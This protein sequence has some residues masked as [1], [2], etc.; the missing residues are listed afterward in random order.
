MISAFISLFLLA[1]TS[2]PPVS[3]F[4]AIRARA[5]QAATAGDN[6][7][8][9]ELYQDELFAAENLGPGNFRLARALNDL[10]E[11]NLNSGH[12]EK[13]LSLFQRAMALCQAKLPLA[14]DPN[15]KLH[16]D[17]DRNWA[18]EGVRS[19]FGA[20]KIHAGLGFF[21]EAKDE[22]RDAKQFCLLLADSKHLAELEKYHAN[23]QK[24][25]IRTN[26][27]FDDAIMGN[28][29]PAFNNSAARRMLRKRR[30]QL[31]SQ[32]IDAKHM[33]EKEWLSQLDQA[34]REFGG[35]KD[36][37]YRTTFGCI[38]AGYLVYGMYDKAQQ[39]LE[40]DLKNYAALET[41]DPTSAEANPLDSVE[42]KDLSFD[43]EQL[44]DTHV[45]KHEFTAAVTVLQ[46]AL[47]LSQRYKSVNNVADLH[48][49]LGVAYRDMGGN[50]AHS[51][52]ELTTAVEMLKHAPEKRL[53]YMHV[54]ADAQ[55]GT[56]M[57]NATGQHP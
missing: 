16:T 43:L 50:Q 12:T 7:R 31:K 52:E 36:V 44:A 26:A 57:R 27:A 1:C 40:D 8:A 6:A 35:T 29:Q 9:D 4:E 13:C 3:E 20:M 15:L 21:G 22:Y 42:S 51:I 32:S 5:A 19:C 39:M 33:M 46:R 18:I 28:S 30:D 41:I 2:K 53:Q 38:I 17:D 34:K 45:R 11:Y 14:K 25:D 49:L 24:D 10:S 56:K 47:A 54:L 48:E 55:R 23:F 37:E